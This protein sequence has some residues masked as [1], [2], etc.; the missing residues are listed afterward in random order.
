MPLKGLE[1]ESPEDIKQN[2]K[3]Q[4][5]SISNE[6]PKSGRIAGKTVC[7]LKESILKSIEF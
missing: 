5:C 4:L 3:L 6:A 1:F 7:S 2:T